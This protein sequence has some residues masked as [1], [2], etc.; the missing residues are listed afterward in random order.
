MISLVL[1]RRLFRGH[2][3]RLA[4]GLA[5]VA[6]WA[7]LF[8]VIYQAFSGQSL[9]IPGKPSSLTNFSTLAGTISIGFIHPI[10]IA[11]YG[12]LSVGLTVGALSGERQRGTLELLL[13]RPLSRSK[14]MATMMLEGW[15]GA[16]LVAAAY[17]V[18]TIIGSLIAGVSDQLAFEQ[19][20]TLWAFATLFWGM[21]ATIGIAAS[22]SF[23]TTAPSMAI[24]VAFIM[25]NY[26]LEVIGQFWDVVEPYRYLSLFNHF[27]PGDLLNNTVDGSAALIFA[28]MSL[29]A[30]A[31]AFY[32]FPRRDLAA[33]N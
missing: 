1:L 7:L 22:G 23:D 6:I 16:A 5:V 30:G 3:I 4:V 24:T 9:S 32:I 2:R 11:L 18:G 20:P 31:W 8:P 10:S 27:A 21:F 19:L 28:I 15:L 12:I 29:I 26:I 13:S 33:P 14:I 25:A 17:V